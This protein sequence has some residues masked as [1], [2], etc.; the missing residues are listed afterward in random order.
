MLNSM[1]LHRCMLWTACLLH[2]FVLLVSTL[3]L[4]QRGGRTCCDW[5]AYSTR[6]VRLHFLLPDDLLT[7]F[8]LCSLWNYLFRQYRLLAP[9]DPYYVYQRACNLM[10]ANLVILYSRKSNLLTKIKAC[11]IFGH[12][13]TKYT[14]LA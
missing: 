13:S 1:Y 2:V 4:C 7:I 12:Q 8:S 10:Q 3:G 11:C 6:A 9:T 14:N 5:L